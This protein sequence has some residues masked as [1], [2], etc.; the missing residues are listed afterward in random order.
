MTCNKT[1][2]IVM[3]ITAAIFVLVASACG[4]FDGARY[5][6]GNEWIEGLVWEG[7]AYDVYIVNTKKSK[8]VFHSGKTQYQSRS[9]IEFDHFIRNY[10]LDKEEH[11]FVTNA[12]MFHEDYSPVGLFVEETVV[13]RGLNR[14]KGNGNFYLMPNG[15]FS[16]NEN[17]SSSVYDSRE[18]VNHIQANK[19]KWATQS[20]PMLVLN[21][22]IHDAFREESINLNIR[23]GVGV[24]DE[25]TVVFA[26]SKE[27]VNFYSFAKLFLEKFQCKNALYLDGAISE[28][29]H[30]SS[31][32][33]V[34]KAKFGT[35]ISV[36]SKSYSKVGSLEE[37]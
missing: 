23:S 18:Y 14:N 35:V 29:Y 9:R 37:H 10:E 32:E 25:Y 30:S 11:L 34:P 24:I 28:F 6:E 33:N 19:I 4:F 16:I 7:I 8:I 26:L 20:G 5:T 17:N 12:G 27:P 36:V 31:V 2:L 3:K 1:S 22:K 15:V 21:G 13:E